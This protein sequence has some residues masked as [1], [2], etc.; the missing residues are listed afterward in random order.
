M[1]HTRSEDNYYQIYD[2]IKQKKKLWDLF[3][4]IEEY[5]PKKLDEHDRFLFK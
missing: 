1:V 2:E 3:T 5:T 4:G